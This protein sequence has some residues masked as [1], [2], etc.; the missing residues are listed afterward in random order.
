MDPGIPMDPAQDAQ[1][2][3]ETVWRLESARIVGG[4]VRLVRD[5]GLAEELAQ[6]AI[7]E[8]LQEWPTAGV[9]ENPGAW[10]ARTARYRAIDRLRREDRLTGKVAVLGHGVAEQQRTAVFEPPPEFEAVDEAGLTDDVLR[11]VFLTCHP[12]LSTPARV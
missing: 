3:V 4:L 11:L 10:L 7:V 2:A 6:D 1:R 8:A 12:V 9:P 5:V